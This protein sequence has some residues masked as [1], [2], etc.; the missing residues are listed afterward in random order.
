MVDRVV[1]KMVY[2]VYGLLLNEKRRGIYHHHYGGALTALAKGSKFVR[3]HVWTSTCNAN[4]VDGG[5]VSV[6]I[7]LALP[8]KQGCSVSIFNLQM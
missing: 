6:P 4:S 8:F 5:R 7:W 2:E 1:G 3:S